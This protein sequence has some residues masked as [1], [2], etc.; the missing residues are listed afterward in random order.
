MTA[1]YLAIAS[2]AVAAACSSS[3][4]AEAPEPLGTL[5]PAG[6]YAGARLS[7]GMI[8]DRLSGR[9]LYGCYPSGASWAERYNTD[10]TFQDMDQDAMTAG[11]WAV[12]QYDEICF[13]YTA[14]PNRG[15]APYCFIVSETPGG[16]H[17][18][19]SG[20][21]TYAASTSCPLDRS[22]AFPSIRDDVKR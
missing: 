14:G 2:L 12:T 16:L 20:T 18:Y 5:G 21:D 13:T 9:T 4:P 3:G 1:K 7:A 8:E 11:T 17:F 19:V 22:Q 15:Q 10:G 6:P